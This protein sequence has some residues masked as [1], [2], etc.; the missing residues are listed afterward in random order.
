MMALWLTPKNLAMPARV[1]SL[2]E[3]FCAA[4]RTVY[5]QQFGWSVH[6]VSRFIRDAVAPGGHVGEAFGVADGWTV[7]VAVGVGVV[8]GDGLAVAV[9]AGVAVGVATTL[10]DGPAVTWAV[11]EPAA[12]A[13]V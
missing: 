12:T 3:P 7:E 1:S 8:V 5:S 11:G 13:W 9:A 2:A 10:A 6:G 4:D